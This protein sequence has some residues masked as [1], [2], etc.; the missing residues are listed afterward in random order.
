MP[1]TVLFIFIALGFAGGFLV[2]YVRGSR[3]KE[4]WN[5]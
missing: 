2:G 4:G 3:S 1:D 5:G